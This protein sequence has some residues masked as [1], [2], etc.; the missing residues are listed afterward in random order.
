MPAIPFSK[1]LDVRG[2]YEVFVAGGGPAGVAAAAAA[3]RTGKSVLL[4]ER[5]GALGGLGTAGLVPAFCTMTDGERL[6]VRGIGQEVV[7]RLR[8]RKGA[9]PDDRPGQ[10]GGIAIQPEILKVVYDEMAAEAGVTLRLW[11]ELVD[12]VREGKAVKAA[13]LCGREGLFAVEADVF[14]DATGDGMLCA[15]AGAEWELGDEHGDTQGMT[16]CATYAGVDWPRYADFLRESNQGHSLAKTLAKAIADRALSVPDF[17]L[18]GVRHTGKQSCGA[19]VGH[20]YGLNAVDDAQLTE[21]YVRGRELALEYGEFY[22]RYVPGFEEVEVVATASL[23]GVRETRRVLGHYVLTVDDFRARASFDD[24]IGRYN[25][26]IDIHRSSADKADY[27]KFW[28]EFTEELRYKKGESYGIPYRCLVPRELDNVLVAGRCMSTDRKMQ[29]STR[30]MPCCYLT[31]QAAGTAA[32]M[33]V[34]GKRPPIELDAAALR[35]R[36]RQAGAYLP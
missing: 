2:R 32:A 29:G 15:A 28:R 30:V 13:V 22:R 35:E 3:A 10:W 5:L 26:P 31:G 23:M 7:E 9:G 27:D 12:V 4:A 19:N 21:A 33:C 24:E 17:H 6:L 8:K 34:D 1:A 20:V 18:P 11:M 25:Y 16:L 36:L 14:V